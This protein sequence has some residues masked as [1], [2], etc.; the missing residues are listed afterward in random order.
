MVRWVPR[1]LRTSGV[2]FQQGKP[3]LKATVPVI[4]T[5]Q[6]TLWWGEEHL[7]SPS[8]KSHELLEGLQL[9]MDSGMIAASGSFS[10][11]LI[12]PCRRVMSFLTSTT[13]DD[14]CCYR[15]VKSQ[16]KRR[17]DLEQVLFIGEF[18]KCR[19]YRYRAQAT[20]GAPIGPIPDVY[21]RR[22]IFN[23]GEH[24]LPYYYL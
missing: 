18:L 23:N 3:V 13:S 12:S 1:A 8:V 16:D 2:E 22:A 6:W 10:K 15:Q 5:W 14:A 20:T 19:M 21:Y 24:G 7:R 9:R 11:L 17:T 4:S